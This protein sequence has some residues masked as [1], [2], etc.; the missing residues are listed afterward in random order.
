MQL[1][2]NMSQNYA[3][4]L[5]LYPTGLTVRTVNAVFPS[6]RIFREAPSGDDENPNFTNLV[7]FCKKSSTTPIQFRDPVPADFLGSRSRESYLVPKHELDASMFSSYPRTGRHVLIAK[8]VG[9][10]DKFQ[11]RSALEHW[12]IMRK[13]IPDAVWENW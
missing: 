7:M 12:S 5:D 2:A 1:H 6:C 10:L 11:D 4:D 3:G 9:R 13:V 8:E